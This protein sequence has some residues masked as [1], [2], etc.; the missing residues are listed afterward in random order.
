MRKC[1]FPSP[2]HACEGDPCVHGTCHP[3]HNPEADSPFYCVCNEGYI[4]EIC[5]DVAPE[6]TISRF[7]VPTRHRC[8]D[9]AVEGAQDLDRNY[10]GGPLTDESH[11]ERI[12][13]ELQRMYPDNDVYYSRTLCIRDSARGDDGEARQ[14]GEYRAGLRCE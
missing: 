10:L 14:Y 13:P 3:H 1:N 9:S 4:G 2:F 7:Y 6:Y 12:L 5:D 8:L 11:A